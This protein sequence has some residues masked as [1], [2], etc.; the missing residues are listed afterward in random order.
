MLA[1]A[2]KNTYSK[3]QES[4]LGGQLGAALRPAITPIYPTRSIAL[5]QSQLL[6][7]GVI[8]EAGPTLHELHAEET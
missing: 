5:R 8:S 3:L 1:F 7:D 6:P 2:S 4:I